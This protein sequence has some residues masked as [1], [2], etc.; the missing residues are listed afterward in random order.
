MSARYMQLCA[1]ILYKICLKGTQIPPLQFR[2]NA[3]ERGHRSAVQKAVEI[4]I[5]L[6]SFDNLK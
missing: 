5:P 4:N 3:R 6:A 1:M 2:E